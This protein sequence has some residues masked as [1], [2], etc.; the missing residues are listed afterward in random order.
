MPSEKSVNGNLAE[1]YHRPQ[2]QQLPSIMLA[3]ADD[4]AIADLKK[5]IA[6]L[7]DKY[8][9]LRS[10]N[11]EQDGKIAALTIALERQQYPVRYVVFAFIKDENA[12]RAMTG[13]F[14]RGASSGLPTPD[15]NWKSCPNEPCRVAT[16]G[17]QAFVGRDVTPD[18]WPGRYVAARE[19]VSALEA[20]EWLEGSREGKALRAHSDFVVV[21]SVTDYSQVI[22]P[23][24]PKA[25]EIRA[26]SVK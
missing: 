1:F 23:G 2:V 21:V 22:S 24:T 7:T 9:A 14:A 25:E 6:D 26:I 8:D 17:N 20:S 19:F 10:V 15:H 11:A 16:F 18:K 12:L 3:A 13:P 5:K 4:S